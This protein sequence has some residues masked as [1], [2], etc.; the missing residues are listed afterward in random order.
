MNKE[1]DLS[2]VPIVTFELPPDFESW[3]Q[4]W[5]H[6]EAYIK[7]EKIEGDTTTINYFVKV[8]GKKPSVVYQFTLG[9][10]KARVFDE[11]IEFI[12]EFSQLSILASVARMSGIFKDNHEVIE[13][14]YQ[15]SFKTHHYEK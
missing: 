4:A 9:F 11:L 3:F 8:M 10:L 7:R 5:K 2:G 13:Q 1:I 14:I 15:L 12:P 6:F